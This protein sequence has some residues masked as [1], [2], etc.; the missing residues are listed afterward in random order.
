[1]LNLKQVAH[2]E[3]KLT[4]PV[5]PPSGPFDVGVIEMKAADAVP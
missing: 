4:V 5:D 1:M 2:G 3:V